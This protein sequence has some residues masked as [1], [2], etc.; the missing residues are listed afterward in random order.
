[1]TCPV[2][3]LAVLYNDQCEVLDSHPYIA[4]ATWT[5]AGLKP[6][7]LCVRALTWRLRWY[8]TILELCVDNKRELVYYLNSMLIISILF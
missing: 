3:E 1:M 5:I 7:M 2:A 4:C 6:T 8:R